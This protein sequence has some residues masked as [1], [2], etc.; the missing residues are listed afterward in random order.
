MLISFIIMNIISDITVAKQGF[1]TV[2]K[3]QLLVSL[4]ETLW[5]ICYHLYNVKNMQNTHRGGLLL[6]KLQAEAYN[7]A[8]GNTPTIL[9]KRL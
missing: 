4:N 3:S 9:A 1:L 2:N 5:S 7:F 6:V 8:K